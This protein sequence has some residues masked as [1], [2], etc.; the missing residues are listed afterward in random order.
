MAETAA[1]N[2]VTLVMD[3]ASAPKSGAMS[4]FQKIVIGFFA[5][6][7]VALVAFGITALVVGLTD[8]SDTGGYL[9]NKY[10]II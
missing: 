1:P 3:D 7:G 6:A 8:G 4:S 5:I 9:L 10:I 2:D